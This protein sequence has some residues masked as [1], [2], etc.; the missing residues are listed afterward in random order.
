MRCGLSLLA[1]IPL[2]DPNMLSPKFIFTLALALALPVLLAVFALS[3]V[4]LR[5]KSTRFAT[6]CHG[7]ARVGALL[8]FLLTTGLLLPQF[9]KIFRE[10]NLELSWGADLWVAL[11][12]FARAKPRL[13][14]R[15]LA[16]ALTADVALF[17]ALHQSQQLRW[18][19]KLYSGIGTLL[20]TAVTVVLVW[21]V[22]ST[23][24]QLAVNLS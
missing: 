12:D 15:I 5:A 6:I 13:V 22:V 8:L 24:S 10:F 3:L 17:W 1:S 16:T 18:L 23:Y 7:S 2:V 14:T 11:Y 9:M 4:S 19:G 21:G 20:L